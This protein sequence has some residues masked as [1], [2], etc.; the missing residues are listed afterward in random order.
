ME[1]TIASVARDETHR[2]VEL[3]LREL[4]DAWTVRDPDRMRQSFDTTD[5]LVVW[6]TDTWEGLHGRNELDRDFGRWIATCPPWT[7][8]EAARR[9]IG[10]DANIVWVAD[11]LEGRWASPTMEGV[12][13]LRMTTIWGKSEG[14][15]LVAHAHLA[16]PR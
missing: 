11:E 15:W 1:T 7:S 10:G 4:Y 2:E 6:G 5:S 9:V 3:A 16:E 13:R 12:A 8:I 14:K